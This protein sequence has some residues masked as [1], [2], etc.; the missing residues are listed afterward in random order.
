MAELDAAG[1]LAPLPE[2]QPKQQNKGI[3]VT[4]NRKFPDYARCLAAKNNDRSEADASFVRISLDRGFSENEIER[5]VLEVS[6]RAKEKKKSG[7][8][9]DYFRRTFEFCSR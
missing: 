3:Y 1:L 9:S 8:F 6:E 5:Q 7:H 4:A 2:P